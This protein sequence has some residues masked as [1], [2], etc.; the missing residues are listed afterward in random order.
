MSSHRRL[1]SA[2]TAYRIGDPEGEFPIWDDGG[3]RLASGRWHEAGATVIYAWKHY[4][5]AMLEKLVHFEGE[6]PGGQHFMEISIPVGTSYEVV[7]PDLIEG[8]SAPDGEAARSFGR[9]WFHEERSAVLI[10]PS[11]V[12][13]MEQNIIFNTG[14]SEFVS[15]TTG[16]ETPIWWNDRLFR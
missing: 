15:V 10:V 2:L 12:A 6:I 11:V 1:D 13:R 7:N 9:K 4:S 16:L 5:T 8:W 14:H 3:A